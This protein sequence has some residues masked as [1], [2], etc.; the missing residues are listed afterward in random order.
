MRFVTAIILMNF[1]CCLSPAIIDCSDDESINNAINLA[2]YYFPE[3]SIN[4]LSMRVIC[5]D[6]SEMNADCFIQFFGGDYPYHKSSIVARKDQAASCVIH[7]AMHI[8]LYHSTTRTYESSCV[9]H[10]KICGWDDALIKKINNELK[11]N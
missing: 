6:R 4:I 11:G 10:D 9:S 3:S 8:N 7:E 2:S 5:R 1:T